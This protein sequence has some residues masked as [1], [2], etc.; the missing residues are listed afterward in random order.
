MFT[1]IDHVMIAVAGLQQGMD[2]FAAMGFNIAMGGEHPGRGTHNA[3]AF[4]QTDYIELIAIH[5]LPEHLASVAG[6]RSG[7]GGLPD[8][9]AAGGGVRYIVIGSND[10]SADVAAMR[11]RGVDVGDPLDGSRTTPAGQTLRWRSASLAPGVD[12]PVFFIQH[13]TPLAERQ[14]PAPNAGKH[15][16]GVRYLERVYIAVKDIRASAGLYARVLGLPAPP[17]QRGNVIKADMTPFQIGPSGIVPAQPMEP[18]P[19]QEA[20]DRRGPGPFQVL[21]RTD[22]MGAADAWMDGHGVPPR[23]RGVRN[24]GE[25]AMLVPPGYACGAYI[26]FVGMPSV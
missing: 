26:G 15:P 7:D 9:I 13:L 22:A 17:P 10:L 25:H 2:H 20:M 16:N 24:T 1:H 5:N 3:I 6:G 18:G 4:N 23:A 14:A 19:A 12:M 11:N 8:F 21:Y